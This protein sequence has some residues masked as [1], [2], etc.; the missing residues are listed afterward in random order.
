[1]GNITN[2]RDEFDYIVSQTM[3]YLYDAGIYNMVLGISGGIDSTLVAAIG[4]RICQL[5]PKFQL[6][7]MSLMTDTNKN[8]EL[9]NAYNVCDEFCSYFIDDNI[10][11]ECDA[12]IN[13]CISDI[14][15]INGSEDIS[16]LAKGN[17]KARYRMLKIYNVAG[18]LNGIVLDTDN[19]T[20]NLLGFFTIHGDQ[21]DYNPI[22][23]LWKHEIFEM[24]S[25]MST[26]KDIFTEKQR[27]IFID[28]FNITPTDGNGVLEGGD[29]AQIAPGCTFVQVDNI[30]N[31][32]FLYEMNITELIMKYP[33]VSAENIKKIYHRHKSSE[34]KRRYIN[35]PK[36]S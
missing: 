25:H 13:S 21:G 26:W 24:I 34:F 28:A 14:H 19:A 7:G 35:I 32:I 20:E 8:E 12:V 18:C 23:G 36:P 22:G 33:D 15:A 3:T 6:I 4:Y 1:M 30:L 2:Y 16:N 5:D 11:K 17:I 29:M 27:S 31:D 9:D 10:S